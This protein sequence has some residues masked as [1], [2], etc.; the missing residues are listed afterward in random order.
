[1]MDAPAD[2][3]KDDPAAITEAVKMTYQ[4]SRHIA[5]SIAAALGLCI[6]L[7]AVLR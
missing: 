7:R 5:V 1:M 2:L 3:F 6:S 4:L